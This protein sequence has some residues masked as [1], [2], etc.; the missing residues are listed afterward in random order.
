MGLSGVATTARL[1]SAR[2]FRLR[3]HRRGWCRRQRRRSAGSRDA[4]ES[5]CEWPGPSRAG[6]RAGS[7]GA[8][9]GA[10]MPR[11]G[12]HDAPLTRRMKPCRE[13]GPCRRFGQA[14]GCRTRRNGRIRRDG[15]ATRSTLR[16]PATRHRCRWRNR[17]I[18]PDRRTSPKHH[19][20]CQLCHIACA[21]LHKQI[22]QLIRRWWDNSLNPAGRDR[23]TR[24]PTIDIDVGQHEEPAGPIERTS[25]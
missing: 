12:R 24:S 9:R 19:R 11:A 22:A 23:D 21:Q 1:V 6:P 8:N 5:R 4:G 15:A 10:K 20:N 3:R 13:A 18:R 7:A 14:P 17:A 2:L 25:A 16:L